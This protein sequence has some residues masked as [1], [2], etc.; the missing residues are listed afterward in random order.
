MQTCSYCGNKIRDKAKYC[1]NCNAYLKL[2]NLEIQFYP[3]KYEKIRSLE[4]A[5]K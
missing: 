4:K 3:K 2:N 5:I 1:D